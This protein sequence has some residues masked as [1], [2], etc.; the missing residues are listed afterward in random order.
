MEV[1][2]IFS[3]TCQ[4]YILFGQNFLTLPAPSLMYKKATMQCQIEVTQTIALQ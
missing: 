4:K 2:S 1:L 3:K